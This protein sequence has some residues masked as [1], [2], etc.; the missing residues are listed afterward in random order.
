MSK[1]PAVIGFT[2]TCL[3]IMHSLVCICRNHRRD[4]IR[5][6]QCSWW[7]RRRRGV[8]KRENRAGR[9]EALVIKDAVGFRMR[10]DPTYRTPSRTDASMLTYFGDFLSVT[11]DS[12]Q[13]EAPDSDATFPS[14][15]CNKFQKSTWFSCACV[16][17]WTR[18]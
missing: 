9:F 8:T 17:P 3:S 18:Y 14:V 10:L 4:P 1:R 5:Q 6:E 15:V 11:L 16:A 7:S 13:I 12:D 2:C